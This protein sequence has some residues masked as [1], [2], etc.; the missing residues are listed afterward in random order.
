MVRLDIITTRGGDAGQTSLGDGSRVGKESLRIEAIGVV[1]EANATL[2]L[3]RLHTLGQPEDAMLA[4]IQNDLFDL[5]ADLCM[6]GEGGDG[7]LR[8]TDHQCARLE[9]EVAE[10]NA[11]LPPL[12]SF[13]LPG[14]TPAA[15]FAHLARTTARRAE[16]V[17]VALGAAEPV[18]PVAIRYLNR[19]S[20]HLFVLCRRLNAGADVLWVPGQTSG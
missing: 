4:R 19:L 6:P 16:R 9:A 17:V 20:D 11:S 13:V 14:G 15:A 7:R 18:N 1:D 12:H 10:M 3:L 5:G 8:M 2:G